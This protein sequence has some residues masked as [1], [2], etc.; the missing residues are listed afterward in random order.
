MFWKRVKRAG[1]W[2]VIGADVGRRRAGD[3]FQ[4]VDSRGTRSVRSIITALTGNAGT[5]PPW[6]ARTITTRWSLELFTQQKLISEHSSYGYLLFEV[7]YRVEYIGAHAKARI[8]S[9]K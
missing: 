7:D 1:K 6:A 8:P 3:L 4:H 5:G 9:S 2:L